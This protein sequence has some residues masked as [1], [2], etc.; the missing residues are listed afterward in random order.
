MRF[1]LH[2]NTHWRGDSSLEHTD[3]LK[4]SET[5]ITI[6]NIGY[7]VN[8]FTRLGIGNDGFNG[9]LNYNTNHF[10]KQQFDLNLNGGSE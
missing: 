1:F 5:A 6:G 9:V 7:A 10:G 8:S 3:L 4:I 2:V